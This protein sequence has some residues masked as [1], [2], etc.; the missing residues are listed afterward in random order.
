MFG[1]TPSTVDV[2][3]SDLYSK[4][5]QDLSSAAGNTSF[6]VTVNFVVT[7]LIQDFSDVEGLIAKL[8]GIH[9]RVADGSISSVRRAELELLQAAK[10]RYVSSNL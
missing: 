6:T 3:T 8:S 1:D 2:L 10:V 4:H 9:H 7:V 5:L